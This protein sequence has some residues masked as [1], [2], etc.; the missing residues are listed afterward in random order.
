MSQFSFKSEELCIPLLSITLAC[1]MA[2]FRGDVS[3]QI[4][5]PTL[6]YLIAECCKGLLDGR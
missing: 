1:L 2:V 5:Q 3:R 4:D 6:Q